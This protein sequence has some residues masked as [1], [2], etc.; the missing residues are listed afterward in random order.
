MGKASTYSD[1]AGSLYTRCEKCRTVF[2]V[3]SDVLESADPRA[4]CGECSNVFDARKNLFGADN[5]A[6]QAVASPGQ[7]AAADKAAASGAADNTLD[8][9]GAISP[10]EDASYRPAQADGD[11]PEGFDVTYADFKL[12]S[13]DANL[14]LVSYLDATTEPPEID[15][16]AVDLDQDETFSDT[17]FANDETI[18]TRRFNHD[19][20][21][22][23]DLIARIDA[24]EAELD[25]AD[26]V[27]DETAAEPIDFRYHDATADATADAAGL[28]DAAAI[29]ETADTGPGGR[30]GADTGEATA[31]QAHDG[32]VT[33]T[34]SLGDDNRGDQQDDNK[35]GQGKAVLATGAAPSA[36]ALLLAEPVDP[37]EPVVAEDDIA[38]VG[39]AVEG[40]SDGLRAQTGAAVGATARSASDPA[41]AVLVDSAPSGRRRRRFVPVIVPVLLLLLFS[42]L[43]GGLY[44]YRE[45]ATLHNDPLARPFLVAVCSVLGCE[46][47]TRVD[48]ASLRI[49]DKRIMSHPSIP[50]ALVIDVA[51]LNG[52]SFPQRYPV[53]VV[54]LRDRVGRLVAD[55]DFGPIDYLE[56]WQRGDTVRAGQRLD[57][58]LDVTDPGNGS[59]NLTLHFRAA[60]E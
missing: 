23:D 42:G 27:T 36:N 51:F 60:S 31:T 26:F 6:G 37:A 33:E 44:L 56:S 4:R 24:A 11:D 29:V 34:D 50:D 17:L 45:R 32:V 59:E 54:Q 21:V 3:S 30:N 58:S 41:G 7:Q 14:P 46:V 53:L 38:E 57:I 1:V 13:G 18:D 43:V 22:P 39:V 12:F 2:E 16:E 19:G 25:N 35:A 52:A 28:G 49:L 48:L 20:T 47:P 10:Y 55:N 40:G 9:S 5:I 15:F 8:L